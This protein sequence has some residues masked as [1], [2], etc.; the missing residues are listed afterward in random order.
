MMEKSS[1]ESAPYTVD[2]LLAQPTFPRMLRPLKT[3]RCQ[4]LAIYHK[5]VDFFR[6]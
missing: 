4:G 3:V 5:I 1:S 2:H 6:R